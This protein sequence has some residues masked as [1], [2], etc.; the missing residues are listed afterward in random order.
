MQNDI[1][2][3]GLVMIILIAG[4]LGGSVNYIIGKKDESGFK[5]WASR[6]IVGIT[7]SFLMPLFLETISSDLVHSVLSKSD[8]SRGDVFVLFGFCLIGAISSRLL[9][10]TLS[11]KILEEVKNVKEAADKTIKKVSE[12][13]SEV[14]PI[15]EQSTEQ[16]DIIS[17]EI[18]NSKLSESLG[19]PAILIL[20]SLI[21]PR[22]TLR[23]KNGISKETG[24]DLPI[25][26]D[27][28]ILLKEKSLADEIQG[29][30]GPRWFI[31]TRGYRLVGGI[32]G[33]S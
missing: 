27:K 15:I 3:F 6:A 12:L 20:K 4:L 14:D 23:S 19:E 33:K 10:R 1:N 29:R 5:T 30:R 24:L 25:V 26:S 7:A 32:K 9:I 8:T 28:L 13:E 21:H 18:E 2:E 16:D 22:Y 11:D 31:T 17:S